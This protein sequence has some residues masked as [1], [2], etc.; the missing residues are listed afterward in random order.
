[1][2]PRA[3]DLIAALALTPH[4][5][6][7]FYRQL[8]RSGE[9]VERPD[10]EVRRALTTIYF[11]RR[12]D[13]EPLAPGSPTRSG[14]TTRRRDR[15]L[16]L[17]RSSEVERTRLGPLSGGAVP[18]HVVPA[19]WWQSARPLGDYSLVGCTVGPGF[20]FEDFVLLPEGEEPPGAPV[21]AL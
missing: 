16:T 8:F 18:V 7:G 3:G 4:P 6:G 5:E 2:H 21:P 1:M 12:R 20:E 9:T 19:G 11:P 14:T 13:A 17:S 15:A 10:G